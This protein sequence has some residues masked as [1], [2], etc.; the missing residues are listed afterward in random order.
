MPFDPTPNQ[1]SSLS[2]NFLGLLVLVIV[3]KSLSGIDEFVD[4]IPVPLEH[5]VNTLSEVSPD[6]STSS[7]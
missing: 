4:R 5:H 2:E 1:Y 6:V 3:D 7:S